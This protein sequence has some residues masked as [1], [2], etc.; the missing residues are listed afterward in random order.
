MKILLESLLVRSPAV[1][2]YTN[3]KV[4][5][6]SNIHETEESAKGLYEHS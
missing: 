3:E 1:S 4:N 2:N 5:L 6:G